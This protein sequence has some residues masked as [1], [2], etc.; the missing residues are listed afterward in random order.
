VGFAAA[1][2][3]GRIS[4]LPYSRL[5]ATVR[6]IRRGYPGSVVLCDD[7]QATGD[8]LV[9]ADR[10]RGTAWC[11]EVPLIE[12]AAIAAIVFTSGSTGSP[13]PHAKTWRN[14]VMTAGYAC[15][16]LNLAG[17][18]IVGTVPCQHMYGLEAT[19][20]PAL[21]G[22]ATTHTGRPLF[23]EDLRTA[24]DA[25]PGRRVVI[26]TPVHLH[27]FVQAGLPH[28]PVER[29]VS[30][31][32]PLSAASSALAETYFAAPVHEIYG[33]TE[34]GSVA[35]RRTL[36]GDLWQPYA[37]VELRDED[38]GAV[39]FGAHLP[40]P[41]RLTDV[42]Q[43]QSDGR[44]R[45]LGRAADML[46]VAGKRA[47]LTDLT[48]KLLAVAGVQDAAIFVPEPDAELARPVALVVAPDRSEAEIL[49]ALA[50]QVDPVF[51]PRPLRRVERLPRNE[52]G[53]L[54]RAA[55]LA[56]LRG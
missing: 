25:M 33:C 23:P 43:I 3:S 20:M 49:E 4:L 7:G 40:E 46:K 52:V 17:A 31:T 1:L 14:L 10:P 53:K 21:A 24:L 30:A 34:A 12:K 6:E 22:G 51:L 32:A 11:G 5:P 8:E 36:D 18:H 44:F 47:S 26:T 16:R 41:V 35:T 29:I 54:P 45:L 39:V 38:G 50:Q 55:L 56:M 9:V 42:I 2:L 27:A 37:G 15:G 13:Q 48:Q 28:A 19:V